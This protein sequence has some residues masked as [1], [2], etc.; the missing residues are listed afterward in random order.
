MNKRPVA[1]RVPRLIGDMVS[2]YFVTTSEDEARAM[3]DTNQVEYEGLYL[4][5]DRHTFTPAQQP[6]NLPFGWE[7][8]AQTNSVVCGGCAFRY[9][10]EHS[11]SDGSWTCPNCGNGNG[12]AQP[13]AA[14]VETEEAIELVSQIIYQ[15]ASISHYGDE[16][17]VDNS[18]YVAREV[19]RAL[20]RKHHSPC[21]AGNV[22]EVARI[23]DPNAF[24]IVNSKRFEIVDRQRDARE[25][26]AA[27][28]AR[29]ISVS[30][31][32]AH[33]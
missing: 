2:H 9:G 13:P 26:A 15:E 20:A 18:D 25:K 29:L 27:I 21:S 24:V 16:S 17:E 1:F 22:D 4:V 14:P 10:A 30:P 5:G 11:D 33:K 31:Q 28:I 3:A 12:A 19:L 6:A 23:I 32:G 8:Q 7:Y